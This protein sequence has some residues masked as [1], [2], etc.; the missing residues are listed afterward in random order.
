MPELSIGLL[1]IAAAADSINPCVFGAL[2]FL[3]AYMTKVFK[4]SRRMLL[5]GLAYVSSVYIGYFLLGLGILAFVQSVDV[6]MLFYWLAAIIALVAGA[7]EIKDYFFYGKGFTLQIIPGGSKRI[8]SYSRQL[9]KIE[10]KHP[11]LSLIVA[12]L[13]GFFVVI[14]E[15]PCTGAPY[16]AVLGLLS[17][18][19]LS[20]VIPLLVYN[21]IFIL[22]LFAIIGL[23]YLGTSTKALSN[24]RQQNRGLMRLGIG[25][26]LIL[27]GIYMLG[28]VSP[29]VQALFSWITV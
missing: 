28:A 18:G 11:A 23:A 4:S 17:Q 25:I 20:A 9:E 5:G 16:F 2:I 7:L 29:Y 10:K 12:F 21:F 15:L 13:L 14:V 27:L 3:V 8:K 24:W 19:H 26:F 22:P 6:A 1:V